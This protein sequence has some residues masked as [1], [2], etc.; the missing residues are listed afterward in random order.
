[1]DLTKLIATGKFISKKLGRIPLS[2]V[3][4]A[5]GA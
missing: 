4:L 2:K 3:N 1:V 5:L